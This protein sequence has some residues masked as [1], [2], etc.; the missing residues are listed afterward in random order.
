[1][2]HRYLSNMPP[3]A[4]LSE[5]NNS[6]QYQNSFTCGCPSLSVSSKSLWR[7]NQLRSRSNEAV[8]PNS[9]GWGCMAILRPIEANAFNRNASYKPSLTTQFGDCETNVSKSRFEIWKSF[10][11]NLPQI[12]G[13]ADNEAILITF[14]QSFIHFHLLPIS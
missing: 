6:C 7:K 1:V 13:N 8:E 10:C 9:M 11:L 4:G 14:S 5:A 12:G 3:F 2:R